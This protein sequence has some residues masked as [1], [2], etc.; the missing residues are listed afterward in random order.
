MLKDY[1][2]YMT[3]FAWFFL[4]CILTKTNLEF[5]GDDFKSQESH[6]IPCNVVDFST[7]VRTR[8]LLELRALYMSCSILKGAHLS[9]RTLE[10][11]FFW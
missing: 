8:A 6:V 9:L 2:L 1:L 7:E 5:L 10:N 11:L 4:I 3:W